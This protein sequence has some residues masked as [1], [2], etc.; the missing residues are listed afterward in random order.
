M[1]STRLHHRA[2]E[3]KPQTKTT[4]YVYICTY[5]RQTGFISR[6]SQ[7]P[8]QYTEKINAVQDQKLNTKS[9]PKNNEL[10]NMG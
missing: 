10:K 4:E 8:D 6:S 7:T 2:A 5:Y 9:K 1:Q 3:M